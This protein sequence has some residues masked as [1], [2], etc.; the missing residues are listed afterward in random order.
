[1]IS[2]LALLLVVIAVPL[3]A[4]STA[5]TNVTYSIEKGP[6]SQSICDRNVL[7]PVNGYNHE[8]VSMGNAG[9]NCFAT[10]VVGLA[11]KFTCNICVIRDE[12]KWTLKADVMN[13]TFTGEAE[14]ILLKYRQDN[15]TETCFEGRR[16]DILV[17]E[18]EGYARKWATK[19]GP[20][21]VYGFKLVLKPKCFE[22]PISTV[23]IN[24]SSPNNIMTCSNTMDQVNMSFSIINVCIL[25]GLLV[26][27][28]YYIYK[29]NQQNSTNRDQ[30]VQGNQRGDI[31]ALLCTDRPNAHAGGR[32]D[33]VNH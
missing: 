30:H 31:Q 21:N 9:G 16:L 12:E 20:S 7:L 11:S 22:E 6:S 14:K 33:H 13:I 28:Y 5:L 17:L 19:E 1:M 15:I 26:V 8:L 25:V 29:P 27:G 3:Y 2:Y 4:A 18:D 32:P 10:L 23:P 24:S